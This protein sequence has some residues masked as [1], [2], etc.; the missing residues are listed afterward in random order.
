MDIRLEHKEREHRLE[1]TMLDQNSMNW[2]LKCMN[3]D[4]VPDIKELT[5][6]EHDLEPHK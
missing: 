6:H 3:L 5:P 1:N 4:Q 2:D